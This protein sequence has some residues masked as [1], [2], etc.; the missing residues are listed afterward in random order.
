MAKLKGP[1]FS[2][3]A[4]QQL[5]KALVYFTWKGLNVVREYVIPSNP[6]TDPQ[7]KQ[8]SYLTDA[9]AAVHAAQTFAARPLVATD[10]SAYAL[11]AAIVKAATT[12]FNQA[13]KNWIDQNVADKTGIVYGNGKTIPTSEGLDVAV[14][15]ETALPTAGDFWYGASKTALINSKEAT[16]SGVDITASITELVTGTKYFWQ[17]RPTAPDPVVGAY[18]GIY[19]G[20]AA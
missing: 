7:K 15:T 18:S 2:L 11:W 20:V 14:A 4:S 6:K 9:V 1:L 17:F 16:C 13:V 8:R 12:W 5:G 10:V 3:G 19:Y